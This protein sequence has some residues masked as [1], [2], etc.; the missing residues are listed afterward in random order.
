MGLIYKYP[1]SMKYS[2]VI[3]SFLLLSCRT[4]AYFN[5]SPKSRSTEVARIVPHPYVVI[6]SIN[7]KAAPRL[8]SFPTLILS[9][10]EYRFRLWN[11]QL[12]P[13][14]TENRGLSEFTVNIVAG[15][16]YYIC[17]HYRENRV[18]DI[19]GWSPYLMHDNEY[20]APNTLLD[21]APMHQV[22]AKCR[23]REIYRVY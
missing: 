12:I 8:G 3:L 15:Q 16:T 6:F 17:P 4:Q 13:E 18:G 14:S 21:P 19:I 2:I 7:Q 20:V 22:P 5:V 23:E 10:G 1:R 11:R 9:P